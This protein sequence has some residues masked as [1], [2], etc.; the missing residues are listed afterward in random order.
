MIEEYKTVCGE[1][2][3]AAV[4][5]LGMDTSSTIEEMKIKANDRSSYWSQQY[6]ITRIR[7]P[8]ESELCKVMSESYSILSKR[9]HEMA[10]K[11]KEAKRVINEVETFLYGV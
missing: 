4:K 10:E 11:E 2:G 5:K 6:N 8:K 1:Y 3:N 9:I 7:N